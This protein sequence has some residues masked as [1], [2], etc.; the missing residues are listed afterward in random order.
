[1]GFPEVGIDLQGPLETLQREL[2]LLKVFVGCAELVMGEGILGVDDDRAGELL[3][4]LVELA[5]IDGA[6]LGS[7]ELD[8]KVRIVLESFGPLLK[9]ELKLTAFGKKKTAV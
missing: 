3:D 2:G 9:S 4:S 5:G 1:M 8:V 6:Q 7:G